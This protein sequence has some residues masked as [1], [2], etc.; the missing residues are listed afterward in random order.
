VDL[1]VGQSLGTCCYVSKPISRCMS[2]IIPQLGVTLEQLGNR[3]RAQPGSSVACLL[4]LLFNFNGKPLE[5]TKDYF[6]HEPVFKLNGR[7][8]KTL[9][10]A[11]RQVGKSLGAAADSILL[12]SLVPNFKY[13]IAFPLQS[14]AN[15]FSSDYVQ[16]LIDN[17]PF[18][19]HLSNDAGGKSAVFQKDIGDNG[20]MYFRYIGNG[21]DRARGSAS[22][23][24]AADE[25]Q[26]HDPDN[27]E[28]IIAN[29]MASEFKFQ[30]LS[31]TPK[32]RDNYIEREWLKSSQ[33][34]WNIKCTSC[35][36][37][38]A[39]SA[40]EDLIQMLGKD[41]LICAKCG[42]SSI[43]PRV[44]SYRHRFPD[45][46]NTYSGYEMPGPIL[47]RCYENKKEWAI[48]KDAQEDKPPY[49]F[50]N[51]WL[52]CSF[53]SG[54]KL[55]TWTDLEKAAV[56]PWKSLDE[57]QGCSGYLMSSVGVDWGGKGKL[58]DKSK[59]EFISNTAMAIAFL[60]D[61]HRIEIPWLF[62]TPYEASY[63][64][65]AQM[66]LSAFAACEA[67]WMAH[68]AGGGGDLR[69]SIMTAKGLP[70]EDIAPYT[71]GALGAD[72]P[73]VYYKPPERE[74]A[75]VS[76]TVDKTRAISL[77]IELIKRGYVLLPQIDKS[78]HY[79]NDFLALFEETREGPTGAPKKLI[80]R[81]SSEHDDIVHAI[82]FSVLILYHH[83]GLW[84][85]F[86]R[87]LAQPEESD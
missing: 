56:V 75:R 25:L 86:A 3:L 23:A 38:N 72:K 85:E 32:T 9:L 47:P 57:I 42:K 65:E 29:M 52:G 81:I 74:G 36:K 80:R 11:S 49:I 71:Y 68:D 48:L 30:R 26:D 18:F 20:T 73:I 78:R 8:Q 82:V 43:N 67:T 84:P 12:T 54:A 5:I 27:V 31:G 40:E 33:G 2:D 14:Q 16:K 62:T 64:E 34:I 24:M 39:C 17:S 70:L 63:D 10:K 45:R 83:T 1:G 61:D 13:M 22:S 19:K 44:G 79:L 87:E 46:I 4:P 76:Y 66:A 41:G 50:Y 35:G 59:Q 60:R 21:A 69:Q 37:W 15:L 28:V 55:I 7:P 77:V 58:T 51:E 6:F 53:D